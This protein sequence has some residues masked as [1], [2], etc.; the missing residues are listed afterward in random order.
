MASTNKDLSDQVAQGAF[1]LDLFYR[2][3]VIHVKVPPLR[4]RLE[5]VPTLFDHFLDRC[6]RQY[7]MPRPVMSPDAVKALTEYD[8]PGNVRE[9]QNAAERLVLTESAEVIEQVRIRQI[10]GAREAPR[11]A[12]IASPLNGAAALLNR[13]EAS[14]ESFWSVVHGPFMAHDMTREQVA[15]L[16]RLGLERSGG[17]Y[18][19]LARLLKMGEGGDRRLIA[20]LKR[21]RCYVTDGE[22]GATA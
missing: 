9:L 21:F 10:T 13:I 18:T 14:G 8:W 22:L 12:T 16:M 7:A 11:G 1:R 17:S 20:F 4:A 5:D 2:L 15:A 3:N 19:Q 6:C